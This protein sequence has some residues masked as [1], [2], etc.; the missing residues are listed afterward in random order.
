MRHDISNL[1][2]LPHLNDRE[3]EAAIDDLRLAGNSTTEL[4]SWAVRHGIYLLAEIKQRR[5]PEG[6]DGRRVVINMRVKPE[7]LALIDEAVAILCTSRTR[8]MLTA[9]MME[10]RQILQ[11]R[12]PVVVPTTTPPGPPEPPRPPKPREFA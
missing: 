12:G 6:P 5:L 4:A 8:F 1:S 3:F 9:A 11:A 2:E 7:R 10:A